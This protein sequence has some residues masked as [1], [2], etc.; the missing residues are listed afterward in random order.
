M[1][2]NWFQEYIQFYRS[3]D[4][5][6]T[7]LTYGTEPGEIVDIVNFKGKIYFLTNTAG[8]GILNLPQ[9]QDGRKVLVRLEVHN[10]GSINP[11][12]ASRD[13]Y[14]LELVASDER[15]MMVVFLELKVVSV[16]EFDFSKMEWRRVEERLDVEDEVAIFTG[17]LDGKIKSSALVKNPSR[18]GGRSNCIYSFDAKANCTI[19]SLGGEVLQTFPFPTNL[20]LPYSRPVWYFPHQS[21]IYGTI[22][23]L[24]ED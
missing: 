17:N 11:P 23:F 5:K 9:D 15:L 16:Y 8:I 14:C 6:W 21:N 2:V 19:Y 20:P 10:K 22:D 18:W 4:T 12:S 24:Y 13:G 3:K 1:G 7:I